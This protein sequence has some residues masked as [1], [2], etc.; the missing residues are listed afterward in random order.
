MGASSRGARRWQTSSGG[1]TRAR[2]IIVLVLLEPD[3]QAEAER[4]LTAVFG[5]VLLRDVDTIRVEVGQYSFAELKSW[6]DRLSFEVLAIPGAVMTDIDERSNLIRVGVTDEDAARRADVKLRDLQIP[7]DVVVVE[8]T[9]PVQPQAT[10][11]DH[12]RPLIGGLQITNPTGSACSLGFPAIHGV[13]SGFVTNSHCTNT[14]GGVESTQVYSPNLVAQD[15][16]GT[17]ALDPPYWASGCTPGYF[18]RYSD[19]AFIAS[20]AGSQGMLAVSGGLYDL[21][22]YGTSRVVQAEL[23]PVAGQAVS[24]TG[25][26]TATTAGNIDS[27]C[28][29]VA[30]FGVPYMLLCNYGVLGPEPMSLPGDSG[31]P[32][33]TNL[34]YNRKLVGVNWGKS[35]NHFWFSSL[36]GIFNDMGSMTVCVPG[37][38]C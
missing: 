38:P 10:L 32:A 37:K 19:A 14:Q 29:N 22:I 18:C 35:T 3:A 1:S 25:R 36:G 34:T 30:Q 23:W 28:A 26:T 15:W 31:S 5:E 20:T 13:T 27:T 4:A 24:K 33:Y 8:L 11:R 16:V 2:P 21:N 9:E 12:V 6:Y 7:S 17:E